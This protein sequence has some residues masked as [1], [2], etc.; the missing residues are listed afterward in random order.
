M[1]NSTQVC[2][3]NQTWQNLLISRTSHTFKLRKLLK[4]SSPRSQ[5]TLRFFNFWSKIVKW[6][7]HPRGQ[8]GVFYNLTHQ[9]T[10][11]VTLGQN[12]T[13]WNHLG[14][15]S[16]NLNL[17]GHLRV[18]LLNGFR[19]SGSCMTQKFKIYNKELP[20]IKLNLKRSR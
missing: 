13:I 11:R 15:S 6:N 19:Y 16:T 20:Y 3:Q 12:S 9:A 4:I 1:T 10:I 7:L 8:R 2:R 5:E 18:K 17:M 14:W